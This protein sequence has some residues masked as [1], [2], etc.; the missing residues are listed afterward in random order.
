[1]RTP[2]SKRKSVI[3]LKLNE[4]TEREV[5]K[6]GF[7]YSGIRRCFRNPNLGYSFDVYMMNT[8]FK[9]ASEGK[10]LSG[11][12][13]KEITDIYVPFIS[14]S[15]TL[16]GLTLSDIIFQGKFCR[17]QHGLTFLSSFIVTFP[18]VFLYPLRKR[19]IFPGV[20]PHSTL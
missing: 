11:K 6:Y 13:F 10:T 20:W 1:M 3:E 15:Q 8:V 7:Q 14:E 16:Q 12:A 2:L 5:T 17:P 9:D 18:N 4:D 19:F